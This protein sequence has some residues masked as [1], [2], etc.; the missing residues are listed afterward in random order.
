MW[1]IWE[2]LP[3]LPKPCWEHVLTLLVCVGFCGENGELP[4]KVEELNDPQLVDRVLQ[5]VVQEGESVSW[6]AIVGQDTAK[7]LIQETLVHPTLNPHIFKVPSST[8]IVF[9][10]MCCT[11]HIQG[12]CSWH[13]FWLPI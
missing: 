5:E 8:S 10:D 3:R 1:T 4:D 12:V 11:M 13:V 9:K 2:P 7:H 6:D